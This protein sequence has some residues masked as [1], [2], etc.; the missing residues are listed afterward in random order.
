MARILAIDFG[1]KRI[2]LATSDAAETLATP[3]LTL[4][5]SSDQAAIAA[6]ARFAQ[7]EEI[8]SVLVGIPR[9]PEG[10]ES[11]FGARIRAFAAKLAAVTGLE[12]RFH[13]ETLTSDE[14]MRRL[15]GISPRGRRP[16]GGGRAAR[17]FPVE[18]GGKGAM[19]APR[20]VVR[21]GLLLALLALAAALWLYTRLEHPLAPSN[22]AETTVFIPYG[23]STSDIFRRLAS[24][25]IVSPAWMAELY[26]RFARSA[27]PLQ[28]GEYRFPRP[29]GLSD[30]I[31]RMAR[32]DVIR[33]PIVVPEGLDG[34]GD[35]RA[36]LE[37]RHQ[38]SRGVPRRV[39]K[40][41]AHLLDRAGRAGP[42]GLPVPGHVRG[43]AF[44]VRA[45]DRREHA[46]EL[47]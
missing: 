2:G 19:T 11:P 33:Y 45:P 38:P 10:V 29:A 35:V 9:S 34:R 42:R 3:R 6:I 16:D 44:H 12:V 1:E 32:G 20:R 14:A 4:R 26:Y 27:T 46:R 5:R 37:P 40:P 21:L 31:A 13:E 28:A 41:A 43:H 36:L 25:G 23:S 30:V 17:G 18:R 7:E 8:G 47:P 24:E 39:P 22:R 15:P